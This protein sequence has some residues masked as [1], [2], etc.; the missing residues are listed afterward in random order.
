MKKSAKSNMYANTLEDTWVLF[1]DYLTGHHDAL[2]A[3][4]SETPLSKRAHEALQN[5]CAQLGYGKAAGTFVSLSGAEEGEY[6]LLSGK[7]LFALLEGLDPLFI[8][9]TDDE[10]VRRVANAYRTD[11]PLDKRSR[12]FGREVRA[13]S[14]FESMLSDDASKQIAW[15]LLRS[16][17]KNGS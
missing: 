1:A 9:I 7:E 3:V 10:A 15:K 11:I 4:V 8:I 13:F 12:F 5:T 14:A 2:I 16:L 6:P 17:P